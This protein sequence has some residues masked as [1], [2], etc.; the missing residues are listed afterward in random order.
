M[1]ERGGREGGR[2]GEEMRSECVCMTIVHEAAP[3]T[4]DANLLPSSRCP[5]HSTRALTLT[6]THP[7]LGEQTQ[8]RQPHT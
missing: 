1:E 2:E 4:A 7:A 5:L 3:T 6:L 8:Q